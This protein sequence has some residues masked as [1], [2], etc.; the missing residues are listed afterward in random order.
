M[1]EIGI[2]FF[3]ALLSCN[4]SV[5]GQDD[6]AIV[7]AADTVFLSPKEKDPDT[8]SQLETKEQTPKKL[9]VDAPDVSDLISVYKIFWTIIFL[10]AGYF[11]IKF[12]SFVLNVLAERG[13][14]YRITFKGAIPIVKILG[15]LLIIFVIIVG[16]FRPPTATILAFSASIGVAVGFASQ[17]LLKNIFGGII[18]IFDRPFKSGDKIE[19]G[20]YYGE[21]VEIGLRSTRIIT[22]DDSL[23]SIPNGEIMNSA[24]SNANSGEA[25]CQVVAEIF[26]PVD[27]DTIKVR[28]IATQAAAVS[29]YVYLNKPITVLFFHEVKE[30]RSYLK[31]RLKA[32]VMDIR[33]EFKFKSDM[34]E[35]VI[36]ELVAEGI[37]QSEETVA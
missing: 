13:A 15:W 34:T 10:V 32:Y 6:S 11:V 5:N 4:Y 9:S 20:K 36:R 18:I 25:N 33:D 1:R 7:A 29:K 19:M 27:V 37:L 35:L 31:M 26:L 2:Y 24:V 21:V 12:L 30:L 28:A 16:I 8:I 22:P 14:Q 23:V 17:D 3:L